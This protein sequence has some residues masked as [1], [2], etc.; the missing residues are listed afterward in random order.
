[1]MRASAFSSERFLRQPQL[2]L[3]IRKIF[4]FSQLMTQEKPFWGR[5]VTV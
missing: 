4:P 5:F 3:E 1:M 2:I